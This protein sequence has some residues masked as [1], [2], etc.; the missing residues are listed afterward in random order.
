MQLV[1]VDGHTLFPCATVAT[2]N[3]EIRFSGALGFQSRHRAAAPG[4]HY[5][6]SGLHGIQQGTQMSFGFSD[7]YS[8]HVNSIWSFRMVIILKD[9]NEQRKQKSRL[10][11][12]A[13]P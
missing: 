9:S 12:H 3:A 1:T 7:T 4:N 2:E 13:S 6:V 10:P 5:I 11:N 8:S